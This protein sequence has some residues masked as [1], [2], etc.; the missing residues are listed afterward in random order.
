ML[1]SAGKG[2]LHGGRGAQD[3]CER[4]PSSEGKAQPEN[5]EL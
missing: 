2:V 5:T 1:V 3:V 4:I